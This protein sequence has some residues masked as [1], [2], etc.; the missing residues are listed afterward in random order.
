MSVD[1][2]ID[3]ENDWFHIKDLDMDTARG[4]GL[5][6]KMGMDCDSCTGREYLS[7]RCSIFGPSSHRELM[8]DST[9]TLDLING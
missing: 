9:H 2:S 5:A 4:Q 8:M 1:Q 3:N 7:H 6:V